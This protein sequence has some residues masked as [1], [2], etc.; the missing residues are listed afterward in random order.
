MVLSQ[1]MQS[2]GVYPPFEALSSLSRLM[3]NGVGEG[4]TRVDHLPLSAQTFSALARAREV[5]ELEEMVGSEALSETDK[6]YLRFATAVEQSVFNQRRDEKR[7]LDATL[8]RLWNALEK[9]PRRELTMLPTGLIDQHM[10]KDE[11]VS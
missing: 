10:N 11:D 2:A 8:D 5:R 6:S 9:L 1:Q 3:R 4:R 7:D